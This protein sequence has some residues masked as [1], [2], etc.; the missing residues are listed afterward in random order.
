[1]YKYVRLIIVHHRFG[2]VG[3]YNSKIL[4]NFELIT[5]RLS[6]QHGVGGQGAFRRHSHEILQVPPANQSRSGI[7]C[8]LSK[9]LSFILLFVSLIICQ[10]HPNVALTSNLPYGELSSEEL[11]AT[12]KLIA[13]I[14]LATKEQLKQEII[15]EINLE[16]INS[17]EKDLNDTVYGDYREIE[18]L[19]M[20]NQLLKELN[21]ELKDKKKILNELLTKEKQGKNNNTKTY[22]EI[23]V[24]PKPKSKR[25]PKLIIKK[26]D[27][28]DNTD[29]QKAVLQHLQQDKSMQTKSVACKNKDTVIINCMNEENIN[30]R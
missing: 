2:P 13:Q 9:F 22:A 26:T 20:E 19:K 11:I 14:H 7:V 18:T 30:S 17:K 12:T 27:N 3:S 4:F 28:K 8:N 21:S 24:K 5:W 23:T 6:C 1:M 29:L 15:D 25:V 10:D 16:K